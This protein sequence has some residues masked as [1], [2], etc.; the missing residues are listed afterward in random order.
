MPWNTEVEEAIERTVTTSKKPVD[1]RNGNGI[2]V[3]YIK[4]F[5]PQSSGKTIHLP[6][7]RVIVGPHP[8]K[9]KRQQAVALLLKQHGVKAN[10]SYR[11]F[12]ISAGSPRTFEGPQVAGL[13]QSVQRARSTHSSHRAPARTNGRFRRFS[14]LPA[15]SRPSLAAHRAPA[16]RSR[17]AIPALRSDQGGETVDQFERSQHQADVAA[18]S[19]LDGLMRASAPH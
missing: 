12:H 2:S 4:L 9:L 8:D 15:R 1:F 16:L 11:I 10:L 7:S 5:G 3:P 6:I 19:R 14:S 13:R 17:V 18:P